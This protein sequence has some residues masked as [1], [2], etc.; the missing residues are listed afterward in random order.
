MQS[1]PAH[2]LLVLTENVRGVDAEGVCV[3]VK[4][5]VEGQAPDEAFDYPR[6][7]WI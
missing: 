6:Q 4:Q 1:A 3:R 2:S 7:L 5:N